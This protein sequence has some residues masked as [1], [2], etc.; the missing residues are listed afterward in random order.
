MAGL[1]SQAMKPSAPETS[2]GEQRPPA[3]STGQ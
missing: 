2:E 1:T 3:R